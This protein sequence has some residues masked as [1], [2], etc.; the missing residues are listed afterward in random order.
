MKILLAVDDQSS[1]AAGHAAARLFPGA[2]LFICSAVEVAPFVVAEPLGGGVLPVLPSEAAMEAE[3]VRAERNVRAASNDDLVAHDAAR[4]ETSTPIGDPARTI[5]EEAS[6][7][8]A[9]VVVV[10][11]SSRGL[12]ARIFHPSVSDY[13]VR[14]A[15]CPVLVVREELEASDAAPVRA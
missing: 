8:G 1:S 11:R 2:E 13:V 7:I 9:D 4:V 3:E 6:A 12:L 5:C 14:H 15:P 10:G